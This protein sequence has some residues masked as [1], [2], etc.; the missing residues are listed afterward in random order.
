MQA[1][2][3]NTT[4]AVLFLVAS[5]G[6]S[7]CASFAADRILVF[8]IE[9]QLQDIAQTQDFEAPVTF[10]LETDYSQA[11][12][13]LTFDFRTSVAGSPQQSFET[14]VEASGAIFSDWRPLSFPNAN[15][16][17]T[18]P[19]GTASW[20]DI[21]FTVESRINNVVT[22]SS[23]GPASG[24]RPA[25][26]REVS[27]ISYPPTLRASA[28]FDNAGPLAEFA[29]GSRTYRFSLRNGL[30]ANSLPLVELL[31]GDFNSSGTVD[32]AD[33]TVWRDGEALLSPWMTGYSAWSQNYGSSAGQSVVVPEAGSA[34]LLIT[35]VG[36]VAASNSRRPRSGVSVT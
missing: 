1:A 19:S 2:M 18:I 28:N 35:V 23:S 9:E 36:G 6:E 16:S 10:T 24:S 25:G 3:L 22:R 17:S 15:G 11:R 30:V 13:A 32:A 33:Y 8:R 21:R 7:R 26:V 4:L 27:L 20:P 14:V 29:D 5:P 31:P 34:W 12:W